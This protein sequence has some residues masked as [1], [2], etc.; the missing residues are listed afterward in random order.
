MTLTFSP[1]QP[2]EKAEP[3]KNCEVTPEVDTFARTIYG[4]ARGERVKGREA[5]ASVILNRVKRSRLRGGRYWWGNG[6]VS[7]CRRA[8]QF[9]CWNERDPNRKKLEAVTAEN[10]TFA[11]CLRIAEKAVTGELS[12]ATKGATHYHAKSIIPPWAKGK[13]PSAKIGNH[14]FYNN[15]E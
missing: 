5:V 8:W 12:D 13:K 9:S 4:E 2:Q 15:I 14:L 3:E 1:D 11:S 6:I 7:V 10:K